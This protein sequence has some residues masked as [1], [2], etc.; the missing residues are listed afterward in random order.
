MISMKPARNTVILWGLGLKEKVRLIFAEGLDC[1]LKHPSLSEI[2]NMR[3]HPDSNHL[4][5][6]SQQGKPLVD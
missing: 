4:K 6:V 3:R 5:K 2:L 1:C